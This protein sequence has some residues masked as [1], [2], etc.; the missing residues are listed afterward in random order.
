MVNYWTFKN[1]DD[2]SETKLGAACVHVIRDWASLNAYQEKCLFGEA[3]NEPAFAYP[4]G[5]TSP[6]TISHPRFRNSSI[7]CG[8]QANNMVRSISINTEVIG[9]VCGSRNRGLKDGKAN[10]A[11]FYEPRSNKSDKYSW[12]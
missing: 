7:Y 6:V 12:F 4:G 1:K 2:A 5:M 8:D 10:E 9:I 3:K 11:L